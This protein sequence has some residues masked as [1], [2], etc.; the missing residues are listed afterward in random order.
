[1]KHPI[2][3]AFLI[4]HLIAF[5]IPAFAIDFGLVAANDTISFPL[6]CLDTLGRSAVPDSVH[7]LAWFQGQ[8][9]NALAYSARS[10]NPKATAYIDTVSFA[11]VEYYY[12]HQLVDAIDSSY[13]NGLYSGQI[14]FWSQNEPTLNPFTFMEVD[15]GVEEITARIDSILFSLGFDST[16]IQQ[17]TGSFGATESSSTN[18]TLFQWL[19]NSIG[20][21]GVN[22][23]HGKIDGLSLSGG[24]T[25]PE[26][27]IVLNHSDS[28]L[29][30]SVRVVIR[31][32][33][34]STVKVDGLTTDVNGRLILDL[35]SDSYSVALTA[36]NYLQKQDTLSV[37]QGGGTD[38]LW[39]TSFD[40]GNPPSPDLCRVYGWVYDLSGNPLSDIDIVAEIPGEFQPLTYNGVIITPFRQKTTTDVF[41]YWQIDLFP[42]ILLSNPASRYSFTIEYPSGVIFKI[43]TEVPHQT[44]WQLQ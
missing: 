16:S 39:L 44:S 36:N 2:I 35:D 33:D 24:G 42:N 3:L 11:G 27:L 10:T 29:I 34:G 12:F 37:A 31:T 43:R 13:G 8:E 40:P 18:L 21:D 41:G 4:L 7:V 30:Q 20:I 6:V 19:A 25:E 26:T 22:T 23:L 1:M 14:V 32:L 15:A 28:T 5:A 9:A 38:S 17:K